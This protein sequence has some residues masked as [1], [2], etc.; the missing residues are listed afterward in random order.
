V[1]RKEFILWPWSSK[2]NQFVFWTVYL[3][4]SFFAVIVGILIPFI[5][6]SVVLVGIWLLSLLIAVGLAFWDDAA[7]NRI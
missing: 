1:S 7:H 5:Q 4:F 3:F 2:T 6:F